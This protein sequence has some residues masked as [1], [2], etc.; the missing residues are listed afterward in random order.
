MVCRTSATAAEFGEIVLSTKRFVTYQGISLAVAW[1][2]GRGVVVYELPTSP[3]IYAEICWPQKGVRIGET[4]RSIRGKIRHDI[5][6]FNSMHDGSAPSAQLRRTLPIA[7]AAK[8]TGESGFE[9]YV[10]SADPRLEHRGLMQEC[11]RHLYEWVRS[12]FDLVDWN[13]QVSCR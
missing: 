5:R 13:R 7:Q 11:E 8:A 10:V 9:F 12:H 2:I 6:W 1:E 3:G 4:G